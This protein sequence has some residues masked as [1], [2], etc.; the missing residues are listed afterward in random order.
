MQD[1][2]AA[3]DLVVSRAGAISISE[4]NACGKPAILI[5]LPTAAN[6]H[7]DFNARF[8]EEN[9]AAVIMVEDE[10]SGEKLLQT[11]DNIIFNHG[12]L[13]KMSIASRSLAK[14]DAL[15]KILAEILELVK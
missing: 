15:E 8:M 13:Q 6:R 1:A 4:L 7:Q 9:G 14:D 11:I 10:L 2:Y 12:C 3:A 5:P